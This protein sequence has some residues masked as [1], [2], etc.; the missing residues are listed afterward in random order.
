MSEIHLWRQFDSFPHLR[1]GCQIKQVSNDA[2]F[3]IVDRDA[4]VCDPASIA[5][6][7][8]HMRRPVRV[9]F[10][11]DQDG[12]HIDASKFAFPGQPSYFGTAVRLVPGF[13][14][15]PFRKEP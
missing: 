14:M 7:T 4:A 8:N 12:T 3:E 5:R 15:R 10:K 11:A 2:G 13:L 1:W 6:I 9:A